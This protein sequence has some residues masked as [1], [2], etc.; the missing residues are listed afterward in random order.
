MGERDL[1]TCGP[2]NIGQSG[3]GR[4][5]LIHFGLVSLLGSSDAPAG[6]LRQLG[7]PADDRNAWARLLCQPV[8]DQGPLVVVVG[9]INVDYV[10]RVPRRP[11]PGETVSGAVLEI[12]SGG[13]GANQVSRRPVVGGPSRW[14]A[15]SGRT[16]P[17]KVV[18][19]TWPVKG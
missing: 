10:M 18:W 4:G 17:A 7:L 9:S 11:A 14:S 3:S 1:A 15:E 12:D 8:T 2:P 16:Q 6:L 19:Q 13:K 5:D